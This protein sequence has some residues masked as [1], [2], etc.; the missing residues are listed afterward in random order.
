VVQK[1]LLLEMTS[2]SKAFFFAAAGLPITRMLKT[3]FLFF[4]P[5]TRR[6]QII[7]VTK[8]LQNLMRYLKRPLQKQMMQYGTSYTKK[9]ML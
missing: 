6:H 7:P 3:T 8:I 9:P 5:K 2:G 1:S 4:I